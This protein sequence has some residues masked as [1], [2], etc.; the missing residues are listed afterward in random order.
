MIAIRGAKAQ[1]E[2]DEEHVEHAELFHVAL[3][4]MLAMFGLISAIQRIVPVLLRWL[5]R[6]DRQPEEEPTEEETPRARGAPTRQAE[7]LRTPESIRRRRRSE[8]RD[9]EETEEEE[10]DPGVPFPH[11][12]DRGNEILRNWVPGPKM[13]PGP[14]ANVYP[15]PRAMMA[16]QPK[17]APA[18]QPASSSGASS[19]QAPT[20]M[21]IPPPPPTEPG[22]EPPRL[23][24]EFMGSVMQEPTE[25]PEDWDEETH[26]PIGPGKGEPPA[27]YFQRM[28][29]KGG[30][31][32][33]GDA[34]EKG[35]KKGKKGKIPEE[36]ETPAK[37]VQKG[38]KGQDQAPEKGAKKGKGGGKDVEEVPVKGAQKG[39]KGAEPE[40]G[41]AAPP[42]VPQ[43]RD[44]LDLQVFIT[45]WGTRY[46]TI[47]TCPTLANS[48]ALRRSPWCRICC[49]GLQLT[50]ATILY[51]DGP[52]QMVHHDRNCA[53][54]PRRAFAMCQRC[55]EYDDR[56]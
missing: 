15:P 23:V 39:K 20:N 16:A 7:S 50:P 8:I 31:K 21:L 26:G 45:P 33:Q 43:D 36:D 41:H 49:R 22:A 25:H 4:M 53:E 17:A 48:G 47:V 42:G 1:G 9:E 3:V 44:G 5:R 34:L 54:A 19:S 12:D 51:S 24:E 35:A 14:L 10:A 52:G 6:R 38:Q 40:D 56:Y 37:G 2:D 13:P 29:E 55:H 28:A 30:Y 27:A 46:H 32:G 18:D 11:G